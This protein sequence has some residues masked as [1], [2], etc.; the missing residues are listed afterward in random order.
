MIRWYSEDPC[1]WKL[2]DEVTAHCST[3][4]QDVRLESLWEKVLTC[5]LQLRLLQNKYCHVF[6]D[7]DIF[8]F[9]SPFM[10]TG[11]PWED[12]KMDWWWVFLSAWVPGI[13]WLKTSRGSKEE[14]LRAL[15]PFLLKT[16]QSNPKLWGIRICSSK[17]GWWLWWFPKIFSIFI[18]TW[19]LGKITTFD[20]YLSGGLKPPARTIPCE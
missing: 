13:R 8:W 7:S 16:C 19:G 20:S 5:A 3:Q 11:I 14:G 15:D 2:R 17:S 18:P 4:W 6:S 9:V 1:F 10:I 12:G